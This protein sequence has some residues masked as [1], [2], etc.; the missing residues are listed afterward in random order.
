MNK[1]IPLYQAIIDDDETGMFTISLVDKPAV[2]SDFLFFNEDKKIVNFKVEN[3]EKHIVTGVVMRC[4]YPIYRIN[5]YGE[6]YYLTFSKETIEKM[7]E[8]FLKEGLNN[9]VNLQH[10]PNNY[11]NDVLL[12]EIFIKDIERGVNPTGFE[13]ISEGSLF[14]TYH[15]LNDDV[16]DLI[17]KGEFKG[18]SLE[19]YFAIDEVETEEDKEY[20]EI[21]SLLDKLNKIK[22]KK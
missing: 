3:E 2:E 8:K 4:D 14:A 13:N 21:M 11:V 18:Y 1:N 9:N 20:N 6:E 15:I 17:K 7:V 16:W 19:G 22:N 10:N 12:K 5:Q